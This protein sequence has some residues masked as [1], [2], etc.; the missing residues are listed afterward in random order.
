MRGCVSAEPSVVG[1]GV[2]ESRPSGSTRNPSFSMP[3]SDLA[4][5]FGLACS[6]A[7]CLDSV[8]VTEDPKVKQKLILRELRSDLF[9]GEFTP[10]HDS[11]GDV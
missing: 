3:R 11:K 5:I 6:W 2:A 9:I 4:K 7:K 8:E 1:C 10:L